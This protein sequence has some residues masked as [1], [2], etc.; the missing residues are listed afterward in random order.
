MEERDELEL[1]NCEDCCDG[2]CD[3]NHEIEPERFSVT[4]EDGI[5]HHFE[6]IY[7]LENDGK[8]YWITQS[9]S[10]AKMGNP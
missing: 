3:C 7:E 10:K 8:P 5:E 1:H 6:I 2:D 4:D 9:S